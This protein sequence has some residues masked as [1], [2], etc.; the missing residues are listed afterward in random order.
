MNFPG[1]SVGIPQQRLRHLLADCTA[2][3]ISSRNQVPMLLHNLHL[4]CLQVMGKNKV[5][6]KVHPEGK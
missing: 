1:V 6:C 3:V 5:L 4:D 2:G